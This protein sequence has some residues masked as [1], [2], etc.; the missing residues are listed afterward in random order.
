MATQQKERS[1]LAQPKDRKWFEANMGKELN[2][3]KKTRHAFETI[4]VGGVSVEENNIDWLV[5]SQKP[6]HNYVYEI[7]EKSILYL[8]KLSSS[9]KRKS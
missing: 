8:A 9:Q 2:R 4:Y 6:P 3:Y 1:N 7:D 5:S